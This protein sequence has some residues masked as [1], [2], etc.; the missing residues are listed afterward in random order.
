VHVFIYYF[1]DKFW[2]IGVC[3]FYFVKMLSVVYGMLGRIRNF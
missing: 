3:T 1:G 2:S